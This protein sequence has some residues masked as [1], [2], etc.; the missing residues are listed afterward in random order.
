[1]SPC[2]NYISRVHWYLECCVQFWLPH[3]KKDREAEDKWN[4]DYQEY[5]MAPTG[6][7]TEKTWTLQLK[8]EIEVH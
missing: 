7:E 8:K 4:K 1:M 2:N 3:Y 6:G 5:G